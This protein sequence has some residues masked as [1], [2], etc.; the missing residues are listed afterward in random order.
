DT[1]IVDEASAWLSTFCD[2]P[3][4]ATM[5]QLETRRT[6]GGAIAPGVTLAALLFPPSMARAV[7][8]NVTTCN[9]TVPPGATGGL[10][11]DLDCSLSYGTYAV[12]LSHSAKLQL[13]RFTI[14][15]DPD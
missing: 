8:V 2:H 9:Q 15:S 7:D 11:A 12:G 1:V 3:R 5:I 13:N 14:R 10:V 4:R 6:G